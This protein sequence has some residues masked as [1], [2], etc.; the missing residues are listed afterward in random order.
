MIEGVSRSYFRDDVYLQSSIPL[1]AK[2]G[3]IQM[4]NN[5]SRYTLGFGAM[6]AYLYAMMTE[7]EVIIT[8]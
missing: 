8:R 6:A 7:D 5:Y 4:G 2:V 1:D 3:L